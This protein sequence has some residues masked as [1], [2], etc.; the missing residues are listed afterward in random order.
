MAINLDSVRQRIDIFASC[1]M[2]SVTQALFSLSAFQKRY[3][4]SASQHWQVCPE[5]L[6]ASCTECQMYKLADGLLSGRYSK[7]R[8]HQTAVTDNTLAHNPPAQDFQEGLRPTS[9]K[10]LIGKGHEEFATM[11]Q[12]DAEEFFSHLIKVLRQNAKRLNLNAEVQPTEI[13]RFGMEQRLQCR[14]CKKVRYRIDSQDSVGIPVPASEKGKD[15]EGKPVYNDV[16]LTEALEM[17]TADEAL[18]YQCPSCNKKVIAVK[19]VSTV[20]ENN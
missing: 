20:T 9:F 15:A 1:Y 12:Q 16:L 19:Y 5:T 10:A 8:T 11:K 7:P 6:P 14:D 3:Y 13:F 17:V 18:E 2:A 4:P